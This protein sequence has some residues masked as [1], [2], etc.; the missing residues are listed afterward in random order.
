M[1]SLSRVPTG[2]DHG[3]LD[4]FAAGTGEPW[5]AN[6]VSGARRSVVGIGR[7]AEVDR[8]GDH[9][10]LERKRGDAPPMPA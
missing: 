4:A 1:G 8:H 9:V 6:T 7:R 2:S 10:R 5:A 3:C